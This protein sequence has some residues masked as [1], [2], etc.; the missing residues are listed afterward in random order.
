MKSKK[1]EIVHNNSGKVKEAITEEEKNL[2]DI[3]KKLPTPKKEWN[4]NSDQRKLWYWFGKEFVN[5]KQLSQMDLAHLQTL[6]MAVDKRNKMY[7]IINDKNE[8]DFLKMAGSVQTFSTGARQISPEEVMVKNYTSE[9][10]EVSK[11][12]GMSMLHRLKLTVDKTDTSQLSLFE[13]VYN[14]LNK[15]Q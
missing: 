9:I 6:V 14:N 4:L 1:L 10:I 5:T 2:Y 7:K 3:L 8:K 13:Q 11:L 12:F 15:A